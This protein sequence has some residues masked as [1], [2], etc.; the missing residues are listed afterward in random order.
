MSITDEAIQELSKVNYSKS[1]LL[2]KD[3]VKLQDEL[4]GKPIK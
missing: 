2:K 4:Y 1:V 3:F